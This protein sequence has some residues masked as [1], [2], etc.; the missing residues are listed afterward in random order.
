MER[1]CIELVVASL[2]PATHCYIIPPT[3]GAGEWACGF[4][5]GQVELGTVYWSR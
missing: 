3:L 2:M 5:G 4:F 1:A